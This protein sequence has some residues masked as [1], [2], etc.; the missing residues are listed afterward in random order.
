MLE[1]SK[2]QNFYYSTIWFMEKKGKKYI[3][4]FLQF[5]I[6]FLITNIKYGAWEWKKKKGKKKI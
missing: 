6:P 1:I 3:S 5:L 4:I 2:M